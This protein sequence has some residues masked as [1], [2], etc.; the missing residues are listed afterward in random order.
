MLFECGL[1]EAIGTLGGVS[2]RR[3][4]LLVK[5]ISKKRSSF[6]S[7]G[8]QENDPVEWQ[9]VWQLPKTNM[10]PKR[11]YFNRKYCTSSNRWFSRDMLVFRRVATLSSCH[12]SQNLWIEPHC[13]PLFRGTDCAGNEP[14]FNTSTGAWQSFGFIYVTVRDPSFVGQEK[15][16]VSLPVEGLQLSFF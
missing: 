4:V 8:R 9:W 16:L 15:W 3:L 1:G 6:S 7:T 12:P 14:I 5:G 10:S 13:F 2:T 11:D